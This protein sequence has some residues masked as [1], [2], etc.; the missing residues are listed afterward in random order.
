[1]KIP[2]QI[3]IKIKK[4]IK[5]Q[6]IGLGLLI[7]S[8]LAFF[9]GRKS[10]SFLPE[11]PTPLKTIEGQFGEIKLPEYAPL[12]PEDSLNTEAK[13]ETDN[14]FKLKVL[15]ANMIGI[16]E[17]AS[18]GNQIQSSRLGI[19]HAYAEEDTAEPTA[20][21]TAEPIEE[22]INEDQDT[23]SLLTAP[24][25]DSEEET[26]SPSPKVDNQANS[27]VKLAGIRVLGEVKNIGQKTA[28]GAK[29][30]V[31]FYASP[32]KTSANQDKQLKLVATKVASFN[33]NYQ[34]LALKPNEVNVYDLLIPNPPASETITIE[35]KADSES[36]PKS[37]SESLS[38]LKVKSKKL[39]D[40][41]LKRGQEELAYFKFSA[42]LTNLSEKEIVNPGLYV[43]LKNDEGKVI[44]FASK[45]FETDILIPNQE[46]EANL[47][48]VPVSAGTMFGYEVKTFG[49]RI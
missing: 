17:E 48:I 36:A 24:S 25:S 1:M 13:T 10:I 30:I 45:T 4:L 35:F 20:T 47:L 8:L 49:E 32:N 39:E 27:P 11:A 37:K 31:R 44:G 5:P 6:T 22:P 3:P 12:Q 26:F 29:A 16:Y 43:W 34:W 7:L 40:A 19:P 33:Q 23:D 41:S 15:N 9:V 2:K 14:E 21:P 28:K 18:S 38:E 46:M 42:V